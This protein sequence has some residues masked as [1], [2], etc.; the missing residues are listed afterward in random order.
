[1]LGARASCQGAEYSTT[2]CR[3]ISP[4]H[5]AEETDRFIPPQPPSLLSRLVPA[6]IP[7]RLEAGDVDDA[8]AQRTLYGTST[9][10]YVSCP[11]CAQVPPRVHR[12]AV[13][14]LAAL[15]WGPWCVAGPLRVRQCCCH[16][17]ACHR[18]GCPPRLPAVAAPRT[19]RARAL[20]GAAGVW[21]SPPRA[22]AGSRHT[23]LRLLRRLAGPSPGT[24]RTLGVDDGAFR[25][26]QPS[27]TVRIALERRPPRAL[28][29]DRA[30][31]PVAQGL[32]THPGVEVI[33]RDRAQAYADGARY[34][35]PAGRGRA[36]VLRRKRRTWPNCARTSLKALRPWP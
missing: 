3:C 33:P 12:R 20:G 4:Y 16:T 25:K 15:P 30:A 36:A 34:G 32:R 14:T 35:A 1:M 9:A 28:L 7:W 23:L 27:G 5:D 6:A 31:A 2:W 19:A 18:Q 21:G 26:R 22:L 13:R 11:G 8:L 10:P 17:L 29:P 24:P